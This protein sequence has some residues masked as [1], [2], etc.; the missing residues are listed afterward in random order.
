MFWYT[1][2]IIEPGDSEEEIKE[3]IRDSVNF[4]YDSYTNGYNVYVENTTY[5]HATKAKSYAMTASEIRNYALN[6]IKKIDGTIY[7]SEMNKNNAGWYTPVVVYP[8]DTEAEI[9][10]A[11]RMDAKGVYNGTTKNGYNIY[12]ENTTDYNGDKCMKVYFLYGQVYTGP[13][14]I[15]A[16]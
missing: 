10:E 7:E 12:V 13:P 9:K 8:D 6:E 11:L 16:E 14:I 4:V 5:W 3:G 1:P 15:E 2:L